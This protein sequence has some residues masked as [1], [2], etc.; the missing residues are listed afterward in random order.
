MLCSFAG[1]DNGGGGGSGVSVPVARVR[2]PRRRRRALGA[3][4]AR[5]RGQAEDPGRA[6]RQFNRN[7]FLLWLWLVVKRLATLF[8][9]C[10]MSEIS[11]VE[12]INTNLLFSIDFGSRTCTGTRHCTWPSCWG[13]GSWFTSYSRTAP[14]SRS[15]TSSAGARFRRPSGDFSGI[16]YLHAV[17]HLSNV[18]VVTACT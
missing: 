18:I 9:F 4:P 16:D 3:H 2:L 6:G 8:G 12:D 11:C 1:G 5:R 7:F 13:G 15:R 14:P 10:Y 17:T